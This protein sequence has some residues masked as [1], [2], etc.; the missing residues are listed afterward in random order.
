MQQRTIAGVAVSA[1]VMMSRVPSAIAFMN[2]KPPL[3]IILQS[4]PANVMTQVCL[5]DVLVASRA[6]IPVAC[7]YLAGGVN[8]N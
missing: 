2:A 6:T 4:V 8:S 7:M 3:D 1:I 5:G